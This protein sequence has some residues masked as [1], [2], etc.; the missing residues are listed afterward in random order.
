MAPLKNRTSN[1]LKNYDYSSQGYY[2]VTMCT[3]NQVCLFGEIKNNVMV[4]N[5]YG[6]IVQAAWEDL[7]NHYTDVQLDEFIVMPNHVHGIIWLID[8]KTNV[9]VGAG[10]KPAPTWRFGLSE[11]VRGFKTFSSRRINVSRKTPGIIV[12]QRSFY[13]H[14]IRDEIKLNK[15]REYIMNNPAQ[16][17]MDDGGREEGAEHC[18]AM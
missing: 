10:L 7:S 9:D 17:A 6:K 15:I 4:L 18:S 3:H 8:L 11:I 16:W 14:I 13:D 1:R 2:F 5:E 12:W